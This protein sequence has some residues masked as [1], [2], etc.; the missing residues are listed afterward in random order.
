MAAI[1]PADQVHRFT[2]NLRKEHYEWLRK[3][4]H[5]ERMSISQW[6]NKAIEEKRGTAKR[7]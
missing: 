3:V 1:K 5:R 7:G 6:I 4:T 2:L